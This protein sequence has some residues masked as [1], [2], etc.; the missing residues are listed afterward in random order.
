M[1]QIPNN[2]VWLDR[3]PVTAQPLLSQLSEQNFLQ[4]WWDCA[5]RVRE[6]SLEG[7]Q[8]KLDWVNGVETILAHLDWLDILL[9]EAQEI[10][11]GSQVKHIVWSGM[12]GSVQVVHTLSKMGFLTNPRFKVHILDSTDPAQLNDLLLTI[13]RDEGLS[14]NAGEFAPEILRSVLGSM[15]MI[16]VSMGMTSE[17][18]I[19]HLRWF[20]S[21]LEEQQVPNIKSHARVITLPDSYLHHF[22][23]QYQITRLELQLDGSA[24]TP[25]RMSAPTTKV[26]LLPVALQLL[27]LADN[28]LATAKADLQQVLEICQTHYHPAEW[29]SPRT[30]PFVTLG[31]VIAANGRAGRNKV[32]LNDPD[33]KWQPIFPWIEQL[34]EESLGKGGKGFLI[35]YNQNFDL[36]TALPAD[37][38][39][40]TL[41]LDTS[42][43]ESSHYGLHIPKLETQ[44]GS[45]FATRLGTLAALLADFKKTIASYAYLEDIVFTGQP[46]VEA[47]KRYARELRD[48]PA[49]IEIPPAETTQWQVSSGKLILDF[50][51]VVKTG[52]VEEDALTTEVNRLGVPRDAT[53]VYA[54]LL[55][56]ARQQD[57]L[58]YGDLTFNGFPDFSGPLWEVLQDAGAKL[59]NQ[60]LG[61][62]FKL[63]LAPQDYHSTEQSETDGPDELVS[64][65][66]V[67]TSYPKVAVGSYSE[68]FLLAQAL[69]TRQAMQDARRWVLL[70]VLPELPEDELARE[71]V[72]FFAQTERLVKLSK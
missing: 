32:I 64:L 15:L 25:G 38:L 1:T 66:F 27:A 2:F 54:A 24:N 48:A 68:R 6:L 44:A 69:G 16:G 35:F 21:L 57:K 41:G 53:S 13:A 28:Q 30:D 56:L 51:A 5:G 17:E 34:V 7:G 31:A 18:P 10:L 40:L 62:P 4:Q 58:G 36:N 65:R 52:L 9:A 14:N 8:P 26:F 70:L 33:G 45:D 47:Y 37:C 55:N 39:V 19:T 59:F 49:A 63:R 20:V 23:D 3:P 50:S 22:A 61:I 71:L 29:D 60:V 43:S 11:A 72:K 12:G 46:A 67:R 42:P